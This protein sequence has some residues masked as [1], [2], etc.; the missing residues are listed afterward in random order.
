MW[1][2]FKFEAR[3][4]AR[5]PL[6]LA[7][8]IAFFLFA[9]L[10]MASEDV[11][12]GG[13]GSNINL[14]A[15]WAIVYTQ[16][17]FSIIGMFAAIAIVANSITRDYELKTAE[18]FF[19]TGVTPRQFLLGRFGA[20]VLF[21]VLVGVAALLGTL[22]A[23]LMPWLD[24][25]RLGPFTITPYIYALVVVTVPNLFLMSALFFSIAALTRSML[26]AFVGAVGFIVAYIVVS[27]LADP[28]LIDVYALLDPFGSTAFG[29]VSRYWTVYERNFEL[30]PVEGQ[31]LWNRLLWVGLG[32]VALALTAW[33]YTFSLDASP[34]R[35]A[36]KTP[37]TVVPPKL[38]VV[39]ALQVFNSATTRAQFLS[40]VRMDVS[41][42]YRSVP[43]WAIMG[44]AAINVWGGFGAVTMFYGTE[45]LPTT[46]SMLRAIGG[47]YLFFILL[48]I[49][50][51]S[52]EVVYR[53]RQTG[54]ANVLDATPYPGGVMAAAKVVA[55]WFVITMLLLFGMLAGV[56]KQLTSGYTNLEPG[57][58]LYGL[59]FVQG[60]FFFLLAIFA[61]FIQVMAGNKWIGMVGMLT[62]FLAF[63]ALPNMGFEHG[64]YNFGT[65]FAPHSD[66]N[67]YGHFVQPL[68]AF[69]LYWGVFCGLLMLATHLW[70]V[71][72]QPDG[73]GER[74]QLA[75][76][77]F[78]RGV[79]S[80]GGLLMVAFVGLGGWI[81]YNTNVLN[82]YQVAEEIEAQQADYE[83]RYKSL[84]LE[85][86]PEVV[87]VESYVD[88]Y[89]DE[90][91][92]ESTGVMQL[93]NKSDQPIAELM[94][95]THPRAQV[96]QL[97]VSDAV[98]FEQEPGIGVHRFRFDPPMP[99]DGRGELKFDITWHHIGFENPASNGL[100]GSDNRVVFNGTFVNNIEI[101][102]APGYNNGLE[103]SDPNVR[104][105]YELPPIQRLPKL[106][107]PD[108]INRSQLGLS[109]R[110]AFKT[111]FST[112]D[113]QIAIAPGYQVGAVEERDG[114]RIYT[115]EMDDKIWPF[116]SYVSAQY[117]VAK[118]T[119]EDVAIEIYHHPAHDYNV[120]PM[121]RGTKKSL[122]YFTQA[123]SPYQYRQFRIL[124]FPR[125]ASFAQSF[126]NTIPYSEAIGFVAD[127]RDKDSLDTVFY[128]TAHE[129]AHQW[130][131]H[132]VAGARMQGMT[133]I[134]ETLAQYSALMVMEKE[135]GPDKMRRF[136][137]YELDRYLQGRGGE[138]I[139][140]LP[141][142]YSENQAYIHYQK[143][144]L[145][146]YALKEA[147]GEE[148]VNQALRNFLDKFA[149]GTGPFPT[150][151]D[152]VAELRAV[153]PAEYQ[154]LITDMFEKITLY[155]FAVEEATY[156]EVE[157]GYEITLQPTARKLYA[158]GEGQ[159]T[160]APVDTFVDIGVF[161]DTDEEMEDYLLPQPLYFE[162]HRV[163]S[164]SDE[165]I[166]VTVDK[167]PHRVG[168]DP[169]NKM[170][171]R[172]PEDNLKVLQSS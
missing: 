51:Y 45:L 95:S 88:L 37:E 145:I 101:M 133:V 142:A 24:A 60:G 19:A 43:F 23:S 38:K 72:G 50:Y 108:W 150:A 44:F 76:S 105:E 79:A 7:L 125:Y 157:G 15:S 159:E 172:N 93:W 46:S 3:Y 71:R 163:Q 139:E 111:V 96:N 69:T 104:R 167:L 141:L 36:R 48:I 118:D 116:F 89:P 67:Q 17:F 47:S 30:V 153:A 29:E 57:L 147:I 162:R 86:L 34:F 94:I 58:Y 97:L 158:D 2:V 128:V 33:R 109:E 114:R 121:I 164:G 146:M 49:I 115:Y 106:G 64:L 171:D 91:R 87:A 5:A 75:Q 1:E 59:F 151:L 14:N 81:Y 16:F 122:D 82:A 102:P 78:S 31:L 35:R 90:R 154:S 8:A 12:L 25:E 136:L 123:F 83:K 62:A 138:L 135:Y 42:I 39:Q 74:L 20:G 41:A 132:Q 112:A 152:L 52:G 160:E 63:Q 22:V 4:L 156:R 155:D 6:F 68:V 126:P 54:V 127:L 85:T 129:L 140:E 117:A 40:Q 137:R 100:G 165:D 73:L 124:E 149:F 66:M 10:I 53:E 9:F 103:L 28:E 13:L 84:E 56:L 107:D 61:V 119:W 130:W 18:L 32:V 21:G 77:R 99:P 166:V 110:T 144:S 168:I 26:A 161:P 170:I 70:F 120:E 113:D 55:L 134:V 98:V 143:G 11:Q 92:L 148:R 27:S 65:P 80:I 169:Y 131:G